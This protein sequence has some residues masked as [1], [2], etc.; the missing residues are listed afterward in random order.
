MI[1]S[2][3]QSH[4][5]YNFDIDGDGVDDSSNLINPDNSD[6]WNSYKSASTTS[7]TNTYS[8][9]EDWDLDLG[10]KR[11]GLDP[12]HAQAN[13]SFYINASS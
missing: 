13:G 2:S 12:Q 1:L 9:S 6:T 4:K 8:D 3:Q 11:Y 7:N 5:K 10:N